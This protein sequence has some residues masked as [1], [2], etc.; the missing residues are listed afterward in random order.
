[1]KSSK[2]AIRGVLS[3]KLIIIL[4]CESILLTSKTSGRKQKFTS[5]GV[6]DHHL[7]EAQGYPLTHFHPRYQKRISISHVFPEVSTIQLLTENSE[8]E[9]LINFHT[10]V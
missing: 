10:V 7:T 5:A 4:N 2:A 6:K 3:P 9:F 1:M 8:M